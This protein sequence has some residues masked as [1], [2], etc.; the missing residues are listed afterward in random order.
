MNGF[1]A[2]QMPVFYLT[3]FFSSLLPTHFYTL[4]YTH[5]HTLVLKIVNI[6]AMMIKI[7]FAFN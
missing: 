5:G 1:T 7:Y 4:S 6:T 3:L 2:V